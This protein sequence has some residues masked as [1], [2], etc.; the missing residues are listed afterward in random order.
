MKQ[1]VQ[2]PTCL[3]EQMVDLEEG[4]FVCSE[5]G[6]EIQ[7]CP[8]CGE[9]FEDISTEPECPACGHIQH[10]RVA[11]CPGCFVFISNP[12]AAPGDHAICPRCGSPIVF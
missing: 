9:L 8:Q 11:H 10:T 12:D 1:L 7:V 6:A 3:E 4:E 2:C 5:C